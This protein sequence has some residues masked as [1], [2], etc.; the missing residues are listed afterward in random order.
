[1]HTHT[2]TAMSYQVD[3]TDRREYNAAMEIVPELVRR[4][5]RAIDFWVTENGNVAAAALRLAR[6]W[7]ARSKCLRKDGCCP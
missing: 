3:A 1:M 4:E 6:Y 2:H 5:S 7:K